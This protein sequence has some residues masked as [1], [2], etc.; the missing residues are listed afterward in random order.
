[1]SNGLHGL[2]A[3]RERKEKQAFDYCV[4]WN[5]ASSARAEQRLGRIYRFLNGYLRNKRL[6]SS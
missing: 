1:M 6:E 3:W 4:A 2:T 5:K